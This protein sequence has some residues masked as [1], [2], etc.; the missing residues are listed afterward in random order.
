MIMFIP[1]LNYL[2]AQKFSTD[3]QKKKKTKKYG[4]VQFLDFKLMKKW[5]IHDYADREA[6]GEIKKLR[7]IYEA[8]SKS[9]ETQKVVFNVNRR[10]HELEDEEIHKIT[11]EHYINADAIDSDTD[12]DENI[13]AD[14]D[15]LD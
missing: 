6:N 10:D 15:I 4:L 3:G 13:I 11:G 1:I 7:K 5:L 9:L 8:T 14:Q 2:S 12:E